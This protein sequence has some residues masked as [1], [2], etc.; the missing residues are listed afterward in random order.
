MATIV[1]TAV[2][3]ALGG[4]IGA[5]IGAMAGRVVDDALFGSR[6]AE[7]PRLSDLQ[8]QT[9]SYGA[10]I[11]KLF[12]TIRV[13]GTVIWATD[14]KETG[15]SGGKG[16]PTQYSYSA[17][18][19][20]AL[21]GRPIRGVKRIWAEGKLLRGAAGDWK[22]RTR[23]RLHRGD[24]VQGPDPL[25]AS[26]VGI[27]NAPAHRGVAYAVFEDLALADFGNRIPSLTFEVEADDAAVTMGMVVETLGEGA[28]QAEAGGPV[29]YGF[30][31][32]GASVRD[33][34]DALTGPTGGWYAADGGGVVVRHGPG[35]VRVV[36]DEGPAA[37]WRRARI[38]PADVTVAYHDVDR[39]YQVGMQQV[40]RP[41]GAVRA[42]RIDLPAAMRAADAAGIAGDAAARM[43][44]AGE[45]R[46]VTLG[47]DAL[48]VAAGD[49]IAIAGETGSWR[50]RRVR[51]EA[52][53][54]VVDLVRIA[55]ATL[56]P[57]VM[58]AMPVLAADVAAGTTRLQLVELPPGDALSDAP[59]IAA[60]AAGS[61]A[62]WRRAALLAQDGGGWRDVGT[63]AAAGVIG[64]VAVAMRDGPATIEDLATVVEVALLH[65]GM[66]LG[67]ADAD[68]LDHGANAAAIGDE[69][70]QFGR[71]ERIGPARWRLSRLWR[72]R[73]ATEWASG[74]HGADEPFVLL[75]SATLRVVDDP[76]PAI[77]RPLTVMATGIA[78]EDVVQTTVVPDG[79]GIVPPAP[80]HVTLHRD[81]TA[82]R[83]AWL[84]RGRGGWRWHDAIDVPL[85]EE[86]EAYRVVRIEDGIVH[87]IDVAGPTAT[88]PLP[89][90][91]AT[92]EIRQ[93]G[94]YGASRPARTPYRPETN[95]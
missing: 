14:L 87:T 20:V 37:T 5:A 40:L 75:D 46:T 36:R 72:G 77:A 53:T 30:A 69:I 35:P 19:A 32:T 11:P 9:S 12:G 60:V 47:W 2:G 49:R 64:R 54:V 91:P 76:T 65:D 33:A 18:F 45:V 48:D 63:S 10:A 71:A 31:A 24:E 94:T 42:V 1:L 57:A 92:I 28:V 7:G 70:V 90:G 67:D 73:R 89:A 82:L 79:R 13:A 8:V 84:R 59:T 34:V 52:L 80:V 55:G 4:P 23:F 88:L 50:A 44:L 51:V 43:L 15:G 58:S 85:G 38:V 81:G 83:V 95:P 86:R 16:Q 66:T 25:I 56:P 17:S 93:I 41:G 39:D 21:S 29:L 61:A 62:E 68:M 27:G 3:G 78:D 74:G 22:T 26:I 6:G